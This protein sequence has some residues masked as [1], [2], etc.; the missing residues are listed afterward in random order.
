MRSTA[1][2]AQVVDRISYRVPLD[3]PS[4]TTSRVASGGLTAG[5]GAGRS[6]TVACAA[7]GEALV[8]VEA[9]LLGPDANHIATTERVRIPGSRVVDENAV[10]AQVAHDVARRSLP[11]DLR[12]VPRDVGARDDNVAARIASD[13]QT[14]SPATTVLATVDEGHQPPAGDADAPAIGRRRGGRQ[15]AERRHQHSAARLAIIGEAELT[16][17][18]LDPVSVKQW[19]RFRTE[20][21]TVHQYRSPRRPSA[22]GGG[23][24]RVYGDDCEISLVPTALE[25]DTSIVIRPDSKLANVQLDLIVVKPN[26]S[27]AIR[28]AID[29]RG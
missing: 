13:P 25:S 20:R 15:G 5:T 17:G 1:R 24:T 26:V 14:R 10:G 27:H 29:T 16:P 18:H 22:H 9:K 11:R 7:A 19:R 12:M 28:G 4:F 21:H 2:R 23:A 6:G 3:I 8:R